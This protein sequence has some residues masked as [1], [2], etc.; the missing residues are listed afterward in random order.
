MFKVCYKSVYN[1]DFELKKE[2]FKFMKWKN[3]L[4]K[5]YIYYVFMFLV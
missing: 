1:R 4:E 5:N 2:I 3:I